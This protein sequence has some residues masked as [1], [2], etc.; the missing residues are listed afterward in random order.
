[1]IN[2]FRKLRKTMVKENKI[3]KYLLYAIGE[4]VLVVIGILIALQINNNND[5]RKQKKE[6]HE[7]LAKI[8]NNIELDIKNLKEI[9]KRRVEI[10]EY[11]QIAVRNIHANKFDLSVN[12]KAAEAFIDFYFVPNQSGYDALKNS[13]YLGKITRTKVDSLLD[14][15]HV[16]LN[17]ALKEENSYLTFVENMEVLWTSK[18]DM[19]DLMKVYMREDKNIQLQDLPTELQKIVVPMFEDKAFR[20]SITR[21]SFQVNLL[22]DYD[23]LIE[24]GNKVIKEIETY[25]ND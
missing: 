15:Y 9:K 17:K 18:F 23:K 5:N 16:I 11:C 19:S 10:S 21:S 12:V 1:M 14:N 7:Y 2:F 22:A 24:T 8:S 3:S 25:I 6:L 4:I 13:S 20:A